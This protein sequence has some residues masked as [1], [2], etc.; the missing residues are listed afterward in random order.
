M[1]HF[2]QGMGW[3]QIDYSGVITQLFPVRSKDLALKNRIN[4]CHKKLICSV[5]LPAHRSVSSLRSAQARLFPRLETTVSNSQWPKVSRLRTSLANRGSDEESTS[6]FQWG[7]NENGNGLLREF[8]PKG[9]DFAEVTDE[10]LAGAVRI[11]NNRP[12][13]CLVWKTAHETFMAEVSHLA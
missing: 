5:E 13:K 12:R 10:E 4:H 6:C 7:S 2:P 8:F 3:I 9:H 1:Q 11:I